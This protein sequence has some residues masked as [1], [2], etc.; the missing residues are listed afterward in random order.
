MSP[1]GLVRVEVGFWAMYSISAR[2]DRVLGSLT[3]RSKPRPLCHVS[4]CWALPGICG[5]VGHVILPGLS[6]RSYFG[7]CAEPRRPGSCHWCKDLP[8]VSGGD[9][10]GRAKTSTFGGQWMKIG[11]ITASSLEISTPLFYVW[12]VHRGPKLTH[13]QPPTTDLFTDS[14][15]LWFQAQWFN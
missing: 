10:R 7:K 11:V 12:N 13:C 5:L 3:D 9:L 15:A 8:F 1:L 2:L 14:S 6:E 4:C